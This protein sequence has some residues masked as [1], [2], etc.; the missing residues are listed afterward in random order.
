[1]DVTDKHDNAE[2]IVEESLASGVEEAMT[3]ERA[4]WLAPYRWQP[5]QSGNPSGRPREAQAVAQQSAQLVGEG[6]LLGGL[7]TIFEARD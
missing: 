3:E 6:S 1:M 2:P 5:G 7:S 4:P